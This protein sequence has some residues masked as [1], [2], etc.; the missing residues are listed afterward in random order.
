MEA[1]AIEHLGKHID[2]QSPELLIPYGGSAV[3]SGRVDLATGEK[4]TRMFT[5]VKAVA[6]WPSCA[7]ARRCQ[8][9]SCSLRC[10]CSTLTSPTRSARGSLD[11]AKAICA[12]AFACG[13]VC[14][15]VCQQR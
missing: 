14:G 6:R 9:R 12:S 10:A 3:K 1:S 15:L 7:G 11:R 4:K 13:W 8:R 2:G 5:N